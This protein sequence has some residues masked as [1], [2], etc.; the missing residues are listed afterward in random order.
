MLQNSIWQNNNITHKIPLQQ[1]QNGVYTKKS[2]QKAGFLIYRVDFI[3]RLKENSW[4][5]MV[6][7]WKDQNREKCRKKINIKIWNIWKKENKKI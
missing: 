2:H 1:H 5:L 6:I 3:S 7:L 4:K